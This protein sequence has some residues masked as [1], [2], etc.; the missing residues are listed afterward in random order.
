MCL[1]ARILLSSKAIWPQYILICVPSS[2]PESQT[3]RLFSGADD[4]S[5]GLPG[6]GRFIIWTVRW[7]RDSWRSRWLV[8]IPASSSSDWYSTHIQSFL[9]HPFGVF[10]GEILIKLGL[11]ADWWEWFLD[12]NELYIRTTEHWQRLEGN[13]KWLKGTFYTIILP[14][15]T[16]QCV[17]LRHLVKV[18]SA[19]EKN[20]TILNC[21]H[22]WIWFTP[23]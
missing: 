14:G 19:R 6:R 21:T 23:R 12:Y 1:D 5:W 8:S 13:R 17:S 3:S 7:L 4:S 18:A 9:G 20:S 2:L 22:S 15:Q 16:I 11:H 10:F